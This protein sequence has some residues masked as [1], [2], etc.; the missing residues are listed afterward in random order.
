MSMTGWIIAHFFRWFPHRAATGLFPLGNPDENSPVIATGNFSLTV[1]RVRRAV[2]GENLHLLVTNSDGINVWCAAAGGALTENRV[3]DAIKISGLPEKV[4]HRDVI[5]PALSAPGID[6]RA[7]R[8]E[9]GF[10]AKFGPVY[11]KDIPAYLA[12]GMKKTDRMRRARFDLRHRLDM[13]LSMN[14][15]IYLVVALGVAAF[16]PGCLVGMTILFW[17]AMAALYLLVNVIPGK[18]G[19]RQAAFSAAAVVLGWSAVDGIAGVDPRLH[20]GWFLATA[21]IFLAGGFDLAGIATPRK[22][23]PE[24]WLIRRR[25]KKLG[26]VFTERDTGTVALDRE[27]CSGC[28]TCRD[29]CPLNVFGDSDADGKTTFR[30]RD[31]CFTCRG[32]TKQCP[33]SALTIR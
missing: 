2:A 4:A 33:T 22:S 20:W 26:A 13:L 18:T 30:N 14:F 23:D 3:I 19:W 24:Q 29:V 8:D 27:K 16:R 6:R 11:A 1:E 12:A 7:I 9:T 15:G 17:S 31:A 25:V 5:L 32:C 21:V 10:H 28:G